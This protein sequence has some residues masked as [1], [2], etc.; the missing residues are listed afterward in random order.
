[1]TGPVWV[2][3]A[4]WAHGDARADVAHAIDPASGLRLAR[5]L[6]PIRTGAAGDVDDVAVCGQ[7][8]GAE[9]LWVRAPRHRLVEVI[10]GRHP[11]LELC[12]GCVYWAGWPA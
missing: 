12:G 5:A 4:R 9:G 1:V 10:A 11:V 8:L 7:P 2:R 6:A 3:A